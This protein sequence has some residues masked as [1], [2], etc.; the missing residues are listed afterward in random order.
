MVGV[1]LPVRGFRLRKCEMISNLIVSL[2]TL[3][4][5]RPQTSVIVEQSDIS[6]WYSE[7][8]VF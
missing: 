7:G 3:S 5:K 6:I 8:R 4:S 1:F 2:G